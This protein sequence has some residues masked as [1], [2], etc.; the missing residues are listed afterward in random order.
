VRTD[1]NTLLT[2]RHVKIDDHLGRPVRS[3]RPPRLT[4][5]ELVTLAVAQAFLGIRAEARW[6]R[7]L[8]RHLPGA[9][10]Y[11]VRQLIESVNQTLKNS[12]TSNAMTAAPLTASPPA[13]PNASSP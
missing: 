9:F 12:S 6:L 8:P 11:P 13:S 10:R 4:D 2:A 3:G 5:A 1:L 7:F